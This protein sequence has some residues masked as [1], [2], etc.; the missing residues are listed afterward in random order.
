MKKNNVIYN[1]RRHEFNSNPPPLSLI[2][3]LHLRPS[4]DSHFASCN[5]NLKAKQRPPT[6]FFY[7]SDKP[8]M[9]HKRKWEKALEADPRCSVVA[10]KGVG[11][12]LMK[13]KGT[14]VVNA[15]MDKFFGKLE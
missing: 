10:L 4:F 3:V 5:G 11:H 15:E 9:F 2:Q 8:F 7:A 1:N 13:G 6:L 14:A 12:W